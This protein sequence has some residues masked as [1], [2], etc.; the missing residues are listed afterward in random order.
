MIDPDVRHARAAA[1]RAG[2]HVGSRGVQQHTGTPKRIV[3]GYNPPDRF[4]I[5]RHRYLSHS[6][7]IWIHA[8][9]HCHLEYTIYHDPRVSKR[10]VKSPWQVGGAF[11]AATVYFIDRRSRF[12]LSSHSGGR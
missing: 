11:A 12:L 10:S 4:G 7:K 6:V 3:T 5:I 2:V 9:L 8:N 1:Y